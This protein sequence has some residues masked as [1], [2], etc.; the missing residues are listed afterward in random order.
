[1]AD[2]FATLAKGWDEHPGK[3]DRATRFVREVLR[4][5]PAGTRSRVLDFGCGAGLVGLQLAPHVR[6]MTMVDMSPSMLAVLR[7][8]LA[9]IGYGNVAVLEGELDDLGLEPGGQDLIVAHMVLHHVPDVAALV[10]S[11]H[12]LLAPGGLVVLADLTPEDGSFHSRG[13]EVPHQGFVPHE[14]ATVCMEAG[15]AACSARVYNT[16][17]QEDASGAAHEYEQFLLVAD[18]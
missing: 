11:L 3:L 7:Q 10:R 15:F 9:E 12:G 14:L 17:T 18:R 4:E 6:R 8:R 5:A 1:M 13:A 16:F 2:D